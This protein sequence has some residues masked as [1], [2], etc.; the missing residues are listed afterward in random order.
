[1]QKKYKF[2]LREYEFD[3]VVI[4]SYKSADTMRFISECK[5]VKKVI[6]RNDENVGFS[7]VEYFD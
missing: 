6:C 2:P 5:E 7:Q 4:G 3:E 1:M